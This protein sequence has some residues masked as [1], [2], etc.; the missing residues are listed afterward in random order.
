MTV[1]AER[2]PVTVEVGLLMPAIVPGG[3]IEADHDALAD[4]DVSARGRGW[5]RPWSGVVEVESKVA[6]GAHTNE[7]FSV[8][9]RGPITHASDGGVSRKFFSIRIDRLSTSDR[10]RRS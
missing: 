8:V 1:G 10:L 5:K 6:G 7:I 9:V 2:R 3:Y 4:G